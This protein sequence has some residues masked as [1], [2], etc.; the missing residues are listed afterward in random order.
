MRTTKHSRN[1]KR[2]YKRELGGQHRDVITQPNGEL[3]AVIYALTNNIPLPE[4][5]HDHSLHNN[6]EGFRECHIRP[7]LLLVYAYPDD[8]TLRLERLGSHS[9]IFG[10]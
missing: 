1:F 5:Y 2:D 7:D 3:W 9:E 8:E 6:L 4:R 10:L